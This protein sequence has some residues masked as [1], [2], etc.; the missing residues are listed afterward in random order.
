MSLEEILQ[1]IKPEIEKHKGFYEPNYKTYKVYFPNGYG[2]SIADYPFD[3]KLH[4]GIISKACAWG[5]DYS[6]D[7]Y[8]DITEVKKDPEDLMELLTE[9]AE[10]KTDRKRLQNITSLVYK[11]QDH[12]DEIDYYLNQ[13]LLEA[14]A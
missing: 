3:S 13:I 8:T 14:D 5:V 11:A 9:I 7:L 4:V 10:L 6:N 1:Q 12:P 2:A